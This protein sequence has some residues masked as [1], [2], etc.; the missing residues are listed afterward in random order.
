MMVIREH[1]YVR[2]GVAYRGAF[3][4]V[5]GLRRKRWQ[6]GYGVVS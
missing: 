2:G 6:T 3:D 1:I 4:R 5:S